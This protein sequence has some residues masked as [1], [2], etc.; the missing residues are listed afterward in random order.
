M[1]TKRNVV[2][3]FEED[4]ISARDRVK[5]NQASAVSSDDHAEDAFHKMHNKENLSI[6]IIFISTCNDDTQ[7]GDLE[8][9][10]RQSC[11]CIRSEDTTAATA[12]CSVSSGEYFKNLRSQRSILRAESRITDPQ[13]RPPYYEK[14]R[15]VRFSTVLIRDY[16]IILGDHPCVSYGPP[17]TIDWDYQQHEPRDVDEYEFENALSRRSQREMVMNYYQRKYLLAE[18]TE[19]EFKAVKREIKRIK[20][21]RGTTKMFS[22]YH[23]I[24]AVIESTCRKIKR[25]VK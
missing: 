15:K 14:K 3:C 2:P 20:S 4:D 23:N 1:L 10:Y 24:E 9:S 7:Q 8:K 17:I 19:A 13:E 5:G 16:S 18:H 12:E 11:C 25:M 21:H 22:R 6:D